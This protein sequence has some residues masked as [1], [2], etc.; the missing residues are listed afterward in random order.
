MA[1]GGKAEGTVISSV[2]H[3]PSPICSGMC[4]MVTRTKREAGSKGHG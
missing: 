2:V 3:T 4:K 1:V